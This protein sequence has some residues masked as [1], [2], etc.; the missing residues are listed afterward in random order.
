LHF[1]FAVEDQSLDE[2][3]GSFVERHRVRRLIPRCAEGAVIIGGRRKNRSQ[4]TD[5]EFTRGGVE[6]GPARGES[7]NGIVS[8]A[9]RPQRA[10]SRISRGCGDAP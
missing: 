1:T 10:G 5:H 7:D 3:R 2:W 8:V 9:M 6:R 4:Q